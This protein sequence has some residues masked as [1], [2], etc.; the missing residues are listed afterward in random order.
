MNFSQPAYSLIM[1][2]NVDTLS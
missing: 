2:I 1:H